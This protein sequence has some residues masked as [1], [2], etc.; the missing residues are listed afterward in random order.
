ME[1]SYIFTE[2]GIQRMGYNTN[3]FPNQFM[4][5]KMEQECGWRYHLI[6][7]YYDLKE[8]DLYCSENEDDGFDK[9]C[10]QNKQHM[11]FCW[12]CLKEA[13]KRSLKYLENTFVPFNA[14][15]FFNHREDAE[16]FRVNLGPVCIGCGFINICKIIKICN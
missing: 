16:E 6:Y 12:E 3:G 9:S 11:V 1:T 14:A 13:E 4:E 8:S 10:Q 5:A 2:S 7:K 15:A